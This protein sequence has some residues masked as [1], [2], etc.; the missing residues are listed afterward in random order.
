M[1]E[2]L[3]TISDH[4]MSVGEEKGLKAVRAVERLG[5]GRQEK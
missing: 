1:H 2:G 3:I 5:Q 4:G